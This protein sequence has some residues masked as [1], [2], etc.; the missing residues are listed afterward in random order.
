MESRAAGNPARASRVAQGP[1]LNPPAS[2]DP[3]DTPAEALLPAQGERVLIR[4]P[5]RLTEMEA[6]QPDLALA[7]RLQTRELFTTCFAHGYRAVDFL[8]D[9]QGG[10]AYLLARTADMS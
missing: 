9:E 6:Q 8:K 2:R 7:W 3:W 1:V 10:G 5:A 4:V